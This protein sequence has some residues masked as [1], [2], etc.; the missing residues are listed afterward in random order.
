MRRLAV[1]PILLVLLLAIA[2]GE[3]EMTSADEAASPAPASAASTT[4]A[5]PAAASSDSVVVRD[6]AGSEVVSV[7]DWDEAVVVTYTADGAAHRLEGTLRDSGKRKYTLDGSP[8]MF[9]IKPNEKGF[10][11]RSADGTLQWKVKAAAEK[12]KVSN[13][14]E[15]QNPFELKM[16]EEGVKVVAPGEKLMG[17]VRSDAQQIVIVDGAGKETLRVDGPRSAAFGVLLLNDIPLPQRY[18]L[19]AE[20]LAGEQ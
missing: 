16:S 2:C 1:L 5:A 7:R 4:A 14:E 17:R 8:V 10:K 11:L 13:N 12:I 15:N 9:E 6:P 18:I 20:L 3:Q 19:M